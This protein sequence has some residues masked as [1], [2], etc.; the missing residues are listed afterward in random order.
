[1]TD[2]EFLVGKVIQFKRKADGL[3]Q[4]QLASRS[5]VPYTTLIKVES[6]AIKNPSLDVV[7]KLAKALSLSLDSLV[8]PT[9]LR[10]EGSLS[11]IFEDILATLSEP[12]DWM[13]ISGV[14]E[15]DYFQHDR[16]G[17]LRFIDQLKVRG[18]KQRLLSSSDETVFLEAEHLEYRAIP[19]EYFSSVPFY[20]Y[21]DR[22][23]M[24]IWGEP[25]QAIIIRNKHL[26]DAMRKLFLFVWDQA[27]A[28]SKPKAAER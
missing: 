7:S 28:F 8:S 21:G 22:I 27:G 16:E 26:S 24:L 20:I 11:R 17:L 4:E 9:V 15:K 6:G 13:A 14:S 3:T 25:V 18:F 2:D 1:M 5:G 19:K 12:G 10:G 23:A